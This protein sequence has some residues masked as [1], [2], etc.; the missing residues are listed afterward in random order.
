MLFPPLF[1]PAELDRIAAREAAAK[2]LAALRARIEQS[3]SNMAC[4]S[5]IISNLTK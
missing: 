2:E 1:S 3:K 5:K 4:L